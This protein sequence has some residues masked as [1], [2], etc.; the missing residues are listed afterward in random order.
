LSIDQIKAVNP[1]VSICNHQLT[2]SK[3]STWGWL[4][5]PIGFVLIQM[6]VYKI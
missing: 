5:N 4:W 3:M 1:T 6:T 2:L